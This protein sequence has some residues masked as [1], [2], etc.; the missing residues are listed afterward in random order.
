MDIS[1]IE[2]REIEARLAVALIEGYA[3]KLGRKEALAIAGRTIRR[4]A[5]QAGQA[6]GRQSGANTLI[7]LAE[8][9]QTIW[10]RNDALDIDFLT[11][12]PVELR[13][14]VTRCRYAELYAQM[15]VGIW[16][17]TFPAAVMRPL[18]TA[19][20]RISAWNAP[21]RSCRGRP[22][23]ISVSI[24]RSEPVKKCAIRPARTT[25]GRCLIFNQEK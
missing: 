8:A 12:T 1:L 6:L 9:A 14:N 16:A 7:D 15:D 20:I 19:S 10:A 17:I 21:K 13:F 4:M 22:S 18:P 5:R 23:A 11:I 2:Q 25:G 24:W 3:E